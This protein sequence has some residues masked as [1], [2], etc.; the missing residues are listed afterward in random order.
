MVGAEVE[1]GVEEAKQTPAEDE[2]LETKDGEVSVCVCVFM[3][4]CRGRGGWSPGTEA[5]AGSAEGW[6]RSHPY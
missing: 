5:T 6:E 2:G 4:V 1:V 3:F